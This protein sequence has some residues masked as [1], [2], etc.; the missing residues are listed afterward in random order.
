MINNNIVQVVYKSGWISVVNRQ[1]LQWNANEFSSLFKDTQNAIEFLT[2]FDK[3]TKFD[4]A[5]KILKASIAADSPLNDDLMDTSECSQEKEHE[6]A[7]EEEHV[8]SQTQTTSSR[9][10]TNT[11][12][13]IPSAKHANP[14]D[15]G[16][17]AKRLGKCYNKIH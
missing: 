13:D 6:T 14:L 9:K 12:E 7:D 17:L 10:R 16:I 2:R 4:V 5:R 8:L 15:D 11:N 1:F 3:H